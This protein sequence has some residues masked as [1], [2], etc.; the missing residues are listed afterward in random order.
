MTV[1][2][3]RA[4][5]GIALALG[6]WLGSIGN[7]PAL[8]TRYVSDQ[9]RISLRAG[10]AESAK[11]LRTLPSGS[12]LTLLSETPSG[13]FVQVR[14]AEGQEGWVLER[15]LMPEPAARNQLATTRR[16]LAEQEA[17]NDRQQETIRALQREKAAL[18]D[19]LSKTGADLRRRI[20][21]LQASLAHAQEE[22]DYL[23]EQEQRRWFLVGAGVLA[24][25]IILGL[26]LPM[27]RR[28]RRRS[29]WS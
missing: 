3:F 29:D 22:S 8:E 18:D 23:R 14:D 25:G 2:R 27:L 6:L 28:P 11:L 10:P 16:R 13:D 9:L 4:V 7:A 17:E 19:R 5:A 26:I 21:D 12:A 15:F 24:A 1:R 20:D